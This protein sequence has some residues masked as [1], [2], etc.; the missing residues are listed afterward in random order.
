[1]SLTFV[2]FLK[3]F[4]KFKVSLCFESKT[5]NLLKM[6]F[7]F[8]LINFHRFYLV[9]MKLPLSPICFI[10]PQQYQLFLNISEVLSYSTLQSFY[11]QDDQ[12]PTSIFNDHFRKKVN[13]YLTKLG[14]AQ[15][16]MSNPLFV[17]GSLVKLRLFVLLVSINPLRAYLHQE[18]LVYYLN[19]NQKDKNWTLNDFFDYISKNFG[20]AG[21]SSLKSKIEKVLTH[22]LL[23]IDAVVQRNN[24]ESTNDQAWS[25]TNG[26]QLISLDLMLNSTFDPL[27]FGLLT[28]PLGKSY[29]KHNHVLINVI[30]IVFDDIFKL[31]TA[32]VN[33]ALDV[34]NTLEKVL[35]QNNIG[36]YNINCHIIH[37]MCLNHQ[38]LRYL[39]ESRKEMVN[40][41]GFSKLYPSVRLDEDMKLIQE[42][43]EKFVSKSTHQ[44]LTY[45]T[46]ELNKLLIQMER[47]YKRN[48]TI[49]N[50]LRTAHDDNVSDFFQIHD[51]SH[52]W[53]SNQKFYKFSNYFWSSFWFSDSSTLPF[54]SFITFKPNINLYP[55]FSPLITQYYAN[56]SYD[57]LNVNIYS[58]SKNCQTEVRLEH[59]F[60]QSR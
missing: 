46:K 37:Q 22:S 39:L 13:Q 16:I 8:S 60:G 18:G 48:E 20:Q 21:L 2:Q 31:T 30:K 42:L 10:F 26:F 12:K 3:K 15:Q 1:M 45:K 34:I 49:E 51:C 23:I 40:M 52:G 50:I 7:I 57:Y 59:K 9:L 41:S 19:N 28:E 54:I 43:D 27:I 5:S 6:L 25:N 4:K 36:I 29:D 55:S 44:R 14:L 35:Y 33:V 11:N 38:D 56:A 24:Y 47:I 32:K 17:F 58:L 53:Y